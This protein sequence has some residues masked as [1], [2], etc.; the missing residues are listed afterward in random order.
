VKAL[1]DKA[2]TEIAFLFSKIRS[3]DFDQETVTCLLMAIREHADQ[4]SLTREIGDF[5]AHPARDRGAVLRLLSALRLQNVGGTLRVTIPMPFSGYEFPQELGNWMNKLGIDESRRI[6]DAIEQRKD[7]LLVCY[8]AILHHVKISIDGNSEV[9]LKAT[10]QLSVF[11]GRNE[12]LNIIAVHPN[13][14]LTAVT[15]CLRGQD[16]CEMDIAEIED[17]ACLRAMRVDGRLRLCALV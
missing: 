1:S 11:G 3:G 13:G 15:T 14:T 9:V 8:L 17:S 10:C 16:W 4:G 7:E 6:D 12:R 5:V 2:R